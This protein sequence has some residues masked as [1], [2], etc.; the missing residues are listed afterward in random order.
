MKE[1]TGEGEEEIDDSFY[2]T[3]WLLI[4]INTDVEEHYFPLRIFTQNV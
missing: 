1:K 3:S 4:K 2:W